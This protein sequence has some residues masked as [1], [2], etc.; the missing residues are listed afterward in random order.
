MPHLAGLLPWVPLYAAFKGELKHQVQS[1][2][3][4]LGLGIRC[5]EGHL[6]CR[7]PRQVKTAEESRFA[8]IPAE[9]P[10]IS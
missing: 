6:T 8:Q 5:P 7:E 10:F 1:Q 2:F 3:G 9:N 4:R